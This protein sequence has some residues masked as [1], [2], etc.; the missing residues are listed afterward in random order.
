M[1]TLL[2][3]FES[4]YEPVPE[5]GCWIWMGATNGDHRYGLMNRRRTTVQAHRVS[6]EL[7]FGS[8]PEGMN[9]CHHCDVGLCVNPAHLFLGT[10]AENVRDMDNKGRR[11]IGNAGCP[12][13]HKNQGEKNPQAKLTANTVNEIRA[14][15]GEVKNKAE[16]ARLYR[17]SESQV[18]RI[19]WNQ[20]W[21]HRV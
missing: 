9:V 5:A 15:Y 19:V 1:K 6:W 12:G 13:E 10:Q 3:R 4:K 21:S 16:L 18:R 2:E 14:R 17:I 11:N 20:S 7:H 8:V